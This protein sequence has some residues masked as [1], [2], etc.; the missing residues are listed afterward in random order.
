MYHS[1]LAG[2]QAE[3]TVHVSPV[4]LQKLSGLES[5]GGA[6]QLTQH[7]S[8]HAASVMQA[9]PYKSGSC[10]QMHALAGSWCRL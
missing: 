1:D 5:V 9:E 10:H 6:P 3:R 4:V 8:T 2:V 7:S